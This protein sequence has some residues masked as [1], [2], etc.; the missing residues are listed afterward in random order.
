MPSAKHVVLTAGIA[1][2]VVVAYEKF[3]ANGGAAVRVSH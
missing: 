3:T 1:L 2:A